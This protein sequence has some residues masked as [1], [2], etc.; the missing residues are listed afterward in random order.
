MVL[1]FALVCMCVVELMTHLTIQNLL[2]TWQESLTW[3]WAYT[4]DNMCV[5][6]SVLC[7]AVVVVNFKVRRGG[8]RRIHEYQHFVVFGGWFCVPLVSGS[9]YST[10]YYTAK[11]IL[12]LSDGIGH[13]T[14][15]QCSR[16]TCV[17]G[18]WTSYFLFLPYRVFSNFSGTSGAWC[19][20]HNVPSRRQNWQ[21]V[22]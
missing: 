11:C 19:F 7:F 3:T 5:V 6:F 16:L 21:I 1:A 9:W 20:R 14:L 12:H 17:N 18:W 15:H 10:S 4:D 2:K 8:S 13:M 22:G